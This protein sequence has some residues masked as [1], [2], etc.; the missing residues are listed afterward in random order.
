MGT[1]YELRDGRRNPSILAD[2][3]LLRQRGRPAHA[4][5]GSAAAHRASR[6]A[7]KALGP[8]RA[9]DLSFRARATCETQ[10]SLC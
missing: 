7:M 1:L 6:A 10:P 5:K 2:G 9:K 4:P 3:P 8:D